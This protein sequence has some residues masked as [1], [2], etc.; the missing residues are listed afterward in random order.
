[1]FVL[2]A[3]FLETILNNAMNQGQL[4]RP[5]PCTACPDF[6]VIQYADD[7]LVVMKADANQLIFLKALLHSFAESIGL[8]VNYHK[9]N[10][11]PINMDDTRLSHFAANINCKKGT[12]PFTYLGLPLGITKPS[13]E[14]FIP[15][16]KRV[17]RRLCGIEDFLNYGGKLEMFKS[18]LSSLLMFY[19]CCLDIPVTIKDQVV[20]YMRHCLWRKK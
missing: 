8:V 6:P 13:L 4:T 17:Q 1:L 18:V 3:D 7:T 2:A 20:K 5:I 12:L 9:S 15:M 19:M 16:V 14:Y 10:M 11:I